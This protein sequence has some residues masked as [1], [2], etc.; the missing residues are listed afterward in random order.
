MVCP[1]DPAPVNNARKARILVVDDEPQM[2]RLIQSV[3]RAHEVVAAISAAEALARLR[4]GE[5][6]DLIFCDL[7]MPEMSGMEFYELLERELPEL[8]RRVVFLTGGAFTPKA[9]AFLEQA[10]NA[11]VYKPFEVGALRAL[12]AGQLREPG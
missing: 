5:R 1:V 2:G 8:A 7:M 12:V 3:L 9:R 4:S 10:K 6:F 11:R